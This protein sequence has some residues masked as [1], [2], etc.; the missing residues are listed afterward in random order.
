MITR[1]QALAIALGLAMVGVAAARGDI[2]LFRSADASKTTLS[3]SDLRLGIARDN[4]GADL[5]QPRL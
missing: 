4:S 3:G 2:G 1:V 5:S